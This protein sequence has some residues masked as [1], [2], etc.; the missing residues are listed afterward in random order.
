MAGGAA[1]PVAGD[2]PGADPQDPGKPGIRGDP[3]IDRMDA[4]LRARLLEAARS[5]VAAHFDE[6]PAPPEPV[7]CREAFPGVFVSLYAPDGLR[8]CTGILDA[9][10]PVGRAV[11]QCAVAAAT[12]DPRFDPIAIDDL[13]GV[14]FEISVLGP[15]SPMERIEALELGRHGIIVS[16]G[17]RRGLLLPRVA[18]DHGMSVAEFLDAGCR[19]AALPPGAWRTSAVTVELFT[20]EVFCEATPGVPRDQVTRPRPGL[21]E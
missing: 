18:T 17:A 11:M 15:P 3:G 14:A 10:I 5:V 16:S 2:A 12:A 7:D 21:P 13:P 8:G 9:S 20:A 1:T 6:L 19:K 4:A